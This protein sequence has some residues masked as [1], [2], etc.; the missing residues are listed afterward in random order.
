MATSDI[1]SNPVLPTIHGIISSQFLPLLVNP[2]QS[3]DSEEFPASTPLR[4]GAEQLL[5]KRIILYQFDILHQMVGLIV[6][7]A[8]KHGNAKQMQ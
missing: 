8:A 6:S 2:Y 1:A 3:P 4:S 7:A 5:H